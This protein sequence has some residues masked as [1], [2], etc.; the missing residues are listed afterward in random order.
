V[1]WSNAFIPTLREDPSQA[2]AVSHRLL[3]RAGYIRQLTSGV[4]SLLPLAQ[5]TRLKIMQI[6]REEM[7]LIG[8]Q[9]FLLPAL[10]PAE[11]W[12]ESGRWEALD[13]IMFRLKDRRGADIALG[14]THEE[15]FTVIARADL[16]SYR[17]LPQIW[18]QL[19]TKF[20]DEARPKSGLLRVREFTMK[21][22]YS[23]DNDSAG[24]DVAF[25]KHRAAY[26]NIFARCQVPFT[27]VQASSGAMGG[28]QS[29]EFMVLCEAGEDRV[30]LCKQCAYSANMEKAV[31]AVELSPKG[32]QAHAL[33]EFPTPDV[34]TIEDLENFA[35]GAA[36]NRQIKTLVYSL[37]GKLAL[38][39]LRGDHQLNETKLQDAT[40]AK[41]VE[42][43]TADG[44]VDAL[45]AAPGSLGAVG[46]SKDTKPKIHFVIADQVLKSA[47]NMVTG[48]NKDYVHYRGVAMERDIQ[49]TSFHDLR[50]VNEGEPCIKCGAALSISRALEIGHVFKL[51]TR[52]SEAMNAFVVT[53]EGARLPI[54]MGSYGIGVERLLA[55]VVELHHDDKGIVWP[56][57]IA[58]YSFVITPTNIA[59]E[60]IRSVAEDAYNSLTAS[61]MD[62]LLDDRSERAGVKFNDADLIGIPIRITVGKKAKDGIV[63]VYD[64][65]TKSSRDV[66]VLELST[67]LLALQSNCCPATSSTANDAK[68]CAPSQI[69]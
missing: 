23:F 35:G 2:E 51:G 44:I 69:E 24:L 57:S 28:S 13:E 32:V 66:H 20:R 17:Q 48:A 36:A 42:A 39:L 56:S 30:V 15:V 64:R 40:G 27:E 59:D 67:T 60:C 55:A 52:Y 58:P 3:M 26:A 11:V 1:R 18:Y 22:S 46:V 7:S 53:A 54:V 41:L 10:T 61:G 65:K 68:H 21:D 47:T 8:G 37:D 33:E 9:E 34:H 14:L 45:G 38:V 49:P 12:Q 63:E 16:S 4:Y 29:N 6:I 5:R 31:S 50:A 43:A 62:V 25:E 19:Q